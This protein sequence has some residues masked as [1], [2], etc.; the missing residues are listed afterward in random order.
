MFFKSLCFIKDEFGT[1]IGESARAARAITA[2]C[3]FSARTLCSQTLK[4]D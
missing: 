2:V 3:V 4:T 1:D